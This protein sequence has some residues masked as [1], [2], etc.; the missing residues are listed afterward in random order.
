MIN[1]FRH[2]GLKRLYEQGDRSKL[3]PTQVNRI[4]EIIFQLDVSKEALHMNLP[5]YRLHKLTGELKGFWSV[6]VSGNFRIIFRF[7]NGNAYE[8]DLLD[9]H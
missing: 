1:S 3:L 5:G 8:V 4:E 9:Y 6:K 7:E 2:R